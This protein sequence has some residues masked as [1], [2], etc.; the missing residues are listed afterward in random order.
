[1]GVDGGLR[2]TEKCTHLNG[3][4]HRS[5]HL[6]ISTDRHSHS[7]TVWRSTGKLVRH[8]RVRYDPVTKVRINITQ[9]VFEV[10]VARLQ[11]E[12][13][14]SLLMGDAV[15]KIEQA[16]EGIFDGLERAVRG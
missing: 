14:D 2:S 13:S 8:L 1:M 9:E 4:P 16:D 12:V 3:A 10:A 11:A 15:T 6:G 5:L 7:S